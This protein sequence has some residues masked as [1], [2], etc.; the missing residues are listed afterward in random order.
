MKKELLVIYKETLYLGGP[1]GNMTIDEANGWRLEVEKQ[2]GLLGI[3]CLNPL[4]GRTEENRKSLTDDD[5]I[6]RDK[7]DI[8]QCSIMLVNWPERIISNGTA[9]EIMYAHLLRKP[10]LFVGK[11]AMNDIWVRY[12]VTDVFESTTLALAWILIK[13]SEKITPI[14]TCK[15]ETSKEIRVKAKDP[16]TAKILAKDCFHRAYDGLEWNISVGEEEKCW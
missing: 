3:K 9:M 16:E 12:H 10:I 6:D 13:R 11:W 8:E 4:R 2:A 7:R 1:I 5:I 14:Y 15:A